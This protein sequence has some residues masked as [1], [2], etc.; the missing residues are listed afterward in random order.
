MTKTN[1]IRILDQKKISYEIVELKNAEGLSGV[2]VAKEAAEDACEV[3]KTLVTIGASKNH[4]VYVIPVAKQLDLKKAA[5]FVGEK[6]IAMI[7]QKDLLGLTGYVHGGCSPIGMKKYFRTIFDES[8]R[9]HEKIYFSAGK[10]GLQV[11]INSSDIEKAVKA[12]FCDLV[13]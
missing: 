5:K 13:C 7:P 8:A 12:E 11:R 2:E 10:V 4:Y 9:S 6:N 1:A 3:F